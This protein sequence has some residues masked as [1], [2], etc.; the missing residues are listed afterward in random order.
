MVTQDVDGNL[1]FVNNK[2]CDMFGFPREEILGKA[3]SHFIKKDKEKNY[4]ERVD[5]KR[6][7]DIRPYQSI[8][9]TK[10]KKTIYLII[11]PEMIVDFSG[12]IIGKS[13]VITDIS[14]LK[15]VQQNLARQKEELD[16]I[17][18]SVPAMI[19]YKD[20]ENKILRANQSAAESI[21]LSVEEVEGKS[22]FEL[23]P[24]RGA[25]VS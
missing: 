19:W 12:Q 17:L 8:G 3:F 10:N 20:R 7:G 24:S 14:E 6:F 1:T 5:L 21:G 16:I 2:F 9:I 18:N 4:Q 22:T 23:Y 25:T 13:C 15:Y 11:S